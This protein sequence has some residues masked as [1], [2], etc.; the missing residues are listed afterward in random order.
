M[1]SRRQQD[2]TCKCA[3]LRPTRRRRRRRCVFQSPRGQGRSTRAISQTD[4]H[5]IEAINR[6]RT[7]SHCTN[8]LSQTAHTPF[9]PAN[10]EQYNGARLNVSGSQVTGYLS[11][12]M[13][14]VKGRFISIQPTRQCRKLKNS[15]NTILEYPQ[16]GLAEDE[17]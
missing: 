14:Y 5:F 1:Q 8:D 11:F 3:L 10:S 2:A 12:A 4:P 9:I 15:F 13:T 16:C 6:V 17:Y 7:P